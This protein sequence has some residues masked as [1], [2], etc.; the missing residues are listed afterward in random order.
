MDFAA[1]VPQSKSRVTQRRSDALPDGNSAIFKLPQSYGS[2]TRGFLPLTRAKFS[3]GLVI[4]TNKTDFPVFVS[5]SNHSSE[6]IR[7]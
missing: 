7:F 2:K 6:V 3:F 4:G 5:V 1:T